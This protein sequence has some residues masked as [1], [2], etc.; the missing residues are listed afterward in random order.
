M[1]AKQRSISRRQF[2]QRV[3]AGMSTSCILGCQA[4]KTL[5]SSEEASRKPNILFVIVDDLRPEMG[6]Y[7]NAHIKTPH[8]DAFARESLRFSNAYCQNAAC[9]PSRASVMTGLRPA[10]TRVWSLGHKFRETIPDVV[11]MP[12]TFHQHGYHTVSMG[13]IFHNHMPDRISFDEAD[14]KPSAYMTAEMIDRDPE[15]FYYDDAIKAELA[16]VRKQR[17]ARNPRAYAGGWAYG[18]STEC[19]EA[20][21]D[22]FYDGAQTRLALDTLKRLKQGDK[23]FYLALG[24][25]RPHLPFVA[26]KKYW[27]L[28]DRDSLPLAA[29]PFLPKDAPPMAMNSCYELRGCYDLEHVKHPAQEK[30]DEKTARSLKHG[31]YA[32]VSYVDAC[33]GR[34]IKGLKALELDQDTIVV[35]WGDHGWKL[36]EHASWCKQTNYAID[37]KVPLMVSVPGMNTRGRRCERL[38]ELV[39]LYPTLC[40]L[41]GVG[42]PAELEGTSLVPLLDDPTRPWKKAAFC[43]YV[44]RPKVTPD[45]RCYMGFSMTTERYH[46]VQWHSWDQ[47]TEQAGD[48]VAVELYDHQTDPHENINCAAQPA[49]AERV[50]RLAQQLKGGWQA[51]RPSG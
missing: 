29:N 40:D 31:Y 6:C 36:G 12:Q 42:I 24:Y 23:P 45:N 33:F 15:S 16:E 43:H 19:S 13:K 30:L 51:A 38:T 26:P 39:D 18:R 17:L 48:Q 32:S 41:A 49:Y 7:G 11:T 5:S 2:L 22:A 14:L 46:Y 27:D 8:F 1:C 21:D 9:A 10:S 50:K 20:P 4:S 34:L 28:Y 37:T 3:L 35:V 25:F 44:Q 47:D